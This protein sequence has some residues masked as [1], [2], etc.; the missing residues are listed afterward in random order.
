M[1]KPSNISIANARIA[2]TNFSAKPEKYNQHPMP[3][4]LLIL[5]DEGLVENLIADGW[6]VKRFRPREGED[7][8]AA[9]LQVKVNFNKKPPIIWLITGNRKTRVHDDMIEAFDYMEFENIDLI[10]EPYQY[11]VNGK[12]GISAYLKTMYATKVV[13]AFESKYADIGDDDCP[14]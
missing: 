9:Y 1:S 5:E 6:N 4:F 11:D 14:F 13:D 12:T 10:I 7:L 8:G 3:N 2:F